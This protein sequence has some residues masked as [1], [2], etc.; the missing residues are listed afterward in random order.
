MNISD[1]LYHIIMLLVSILMTYFVYLF[2]RAVYRAIINIIR[3]L[4]NKD[5]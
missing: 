4:L 5:K 1:F 3:I 2:W